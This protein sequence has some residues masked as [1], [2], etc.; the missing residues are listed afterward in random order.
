MKHT[1]L[2][3][4]VGLAMVLVPSVASADLVTFRGGRVLNVASVTF[5]GDSPVVTLRTGEALEGRPR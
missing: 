3:A 2:G 4:I 1:R 5:N